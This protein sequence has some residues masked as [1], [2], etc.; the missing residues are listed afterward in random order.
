[1]SPPRVSAASAAQP[2]LVHTHG[3]ESFRATRRPE[4]AAVVVGV[5]VAG[6]AELPL[7]EVMVKPSAM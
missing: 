3:D 2:T 1:M 7:R 5:S 6:L 4:D